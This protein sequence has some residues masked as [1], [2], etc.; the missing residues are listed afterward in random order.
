VGGF[1]ADAEPTIA[2]KPNEGP[3]IVIMS[4]ADLR[5]GLWYFEDELEGPCRFLKSA[6]PET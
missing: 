4:T 2:E 6:R 1:Q 3:K 5:H